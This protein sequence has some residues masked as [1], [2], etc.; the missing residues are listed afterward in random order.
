MEVLV[1]SCKLLESNIGNKVDYITDTEDK[2]E[3]I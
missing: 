3:H 1:T 2:N